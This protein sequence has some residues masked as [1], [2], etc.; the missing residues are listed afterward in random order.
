MIT[1]YVVSYATLRKISHP[2]R[3]ALGT[4]QNPLDCERW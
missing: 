4:T 3:P 1:V 2:L